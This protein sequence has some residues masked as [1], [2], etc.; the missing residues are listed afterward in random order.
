M[1]LEE[2][3]QS[4]TEGIQEHDLATDLGVEAPAHAG[5]DGPQPTRN[6][7]NLKAELIPGPSQGADQTTATLGANFLT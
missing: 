1:T 2:P 6:S 4:R 5:G 7:G 3:R